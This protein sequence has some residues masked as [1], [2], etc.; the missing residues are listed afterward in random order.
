[1]QFVL[2]LRKGQIWYVKDL[3]IF[4]GLDKR[5][6]STS[7]KVLIWLEPELS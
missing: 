6:S 3:S 4:E 5:L 2:L 7:K 1:M